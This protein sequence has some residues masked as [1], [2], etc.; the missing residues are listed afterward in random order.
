M[1][2]VLAEGTSTTAV[3]LA[4][5]SRIRILHLPET[6]TNLTLRNQFN[7]LKMQQKKMDWWLQGY[8]I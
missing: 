8:I 5:G 4:N 3:N 2:T 7:L 1:E 6:I